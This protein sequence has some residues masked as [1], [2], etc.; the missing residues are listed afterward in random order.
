LSYIDRKREEVAMANVARSEEERGQDKL[1]FLDYWRVV[2]KR[3]EIIIAT[4]IIIVFTTFVFSWIAKEVYSASSQIK[5]EQRQRPMDVFRS[6]TPT[7]SPLFDQYEFETHRK[8]LE[9]NSVLTK[10]VLGEIYSEDYLWYCPAHPAAKFTD[11]QA[12]SQGDVC[13]V[14]QSALVRQRKKKYPDWKPLNVKWA[15]DDGLPGRPYTVPGA[16]SRLRRNL[17]IRPEKGTRLISIRFD[18]TDRQEARLVANMIAEAYIQWR[19]E[20]H[21]NELQNAIKIVE[22]QQRAYGRDLNTAVGDLVKKQ[23]KF[24][25]DARDQ[26]IQYQRLETLTQK[27]DLVR[28][29]IARLKSYVVRLNSKSND[30]RVNATQENPAVYQLAVDL[31]TQEAALRS[32]LEEYGIEHPQIKAQKETI[33]ALKNTLYDLANGV[34]EAKKAELAALQDQE[35]EL[36]GSIT[37]LEEEISESIQAYDDY[38]RAKNDVDLKKAI[39]LEMEKS[40]IIETITSAIPRE[41]IQIHEEAQLP[42]APIKPKRLFNVIVSIFV[43][44]TLGT[45]LAYFVDYLDT[46]IKNVDDLERYLNMSALAV[47][48]KQADG[49]L[50]SENPK[51]HAAENYRM[52]WT[53]IEFKRREDKFKNLMVTSG[54]ASE[55]KTTTVVNLGIAA[56][57]ME[58]RVL[59]VDSDLRRPK[60]HKLLKYPNRYGLSDVLLKDVNPKEVIIQT[61]VPG[62][63]VMPSGK[64]PHNVIG[65]LSSEKMRAVIERLSQDYDVVFYDSPPVIGVSDASVLANLVGRV[66]LVIDYR[67][68]PKRFAMRARKGIENV[69]G[70]LLGVVINNLNVTEEDYYY[71]GYGKAYRYYYQKYEDE[72]SEQGKSAGAAKGKGEAEAASEPDPEALADDE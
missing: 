37:K 26:P 3:K 23:S 57:Q 8:S 46:S 53:N 55:G 7:Y 14:C 27:R 13:T 45:G 52:L 12:S 58:A 33:A 25:L 9:S 61:D 41:D 59:L 47:I 16:V 24:T 69:G 39:L 49:L 15:E 38:M 56:A 42:N 28:A 44:V 4:L 34:I 11:R 62:L 20:K 64:L 36:N 2:K 6:E 5:V 18:S 10:V 48:P 19:E 1:H 71:Y 31:G 72:E 43:G 66:I 65:L 67:K 63:S 70:E 68:Y 40:R 30:E 32:L 50:I 60:I 17:R 54:G 51:S 22:R 21:E 29:E 35:T